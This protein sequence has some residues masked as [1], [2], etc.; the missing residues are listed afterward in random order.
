MPVYLDS[1]TTGG[2]FWFKQRFKQ[3]CSV[4]V[5]AVRYRNKKKRLHFC[6]LF[7]FS[8]SAR[9]QTWNR[10]IRSQVLYSVELRSHLL[11]ASAN[12]G[13]FFFTTKYFEEKLK[14]IFYLL[15][16]S[17]FSVLARGSLAGTAPRTACHACVPVYFLLTP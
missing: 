4:A 1:C 13:C 9:I 14:N 7:T 11:I 3:M 15:P 8:D 2:D 5:N 16:L 10:L 6:N 12:I 17:T